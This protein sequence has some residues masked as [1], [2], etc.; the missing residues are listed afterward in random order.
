M[1]S[2]LT[3][4]EKEWNK[5]LKKEEQFLKKRRIKKESSFNKMLEEKIPEK[6]Q[7]TLDVAFAKAFTLIFQKG[8]GIIEKTY[9]K[10]EFEKA[11]QIHEYT[12]QVRQ[13]KKSLRTFSKKAEGTGTRNF[14]LSG[15]SGVG[16]GILGIGIPDI[17]V[18]TGMMLRSIYEI[19]MS[20]GYKYDTEEEQFFILLLIQGAVSY[21]TEI[22]VINRELNTFISTGKLPLN[23]DGTRQIEKTA[24]CLSGEL[25]YMKFLQGIPIVGAAGGIYD[26]VYMKHITEYANLKYKRRFLENQKK[27]NKEEGR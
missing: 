10:E 25:L 7:Q 11:Y 17:P 5:L 24:G 22:E 19:S 18:F 27:I 15:V 21:G 3:P 20:Y 9:K 16:M 1:H 6:L 2:K 14:L 13:N 23:D 4:V 12:H 8:S 26:A